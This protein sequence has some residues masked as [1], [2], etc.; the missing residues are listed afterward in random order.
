MT[1]ILLLLLATTAGAHEWY[2]HACCDT[3]HC[4]PV[5]DGVVEDVNDGVKVQGHGTLHCGDPRLRWSRDNQDHVCEA[6]EKLLCVYRRFKG[7]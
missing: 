1:I 6:P 4:H 5:A 7:T 2:E 3:R